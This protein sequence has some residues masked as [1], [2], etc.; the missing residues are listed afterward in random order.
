MNVPGAQCIRSLLSFQPGLCGD[1]LKGIVRLSSEDLEALSKDGL[2]SRCVWDG[3]LDNPVVQTDENFRSVTKKLAGKLQGRWVSIASDRIGQHVVRK[4]FASLTDVDVGKQ[5]VI[6]LSSGK[7]RLN[8]SAM[9]RSVMESCF[10]HEFIAK[11]EKEWT[12]LVRKMHQ[13]YTLAKEIFEEVDPVSA[14]RPDRKRRKKTDGEHQAKRKQ[15]LSTMSVDAIMRT[16]TIPS[17]K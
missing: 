3:I 2:G 14:E 4:L 16:L 13:K 10:V 5:L 7:A 12:T 8:G 9:G 1:T 11:G 17:S 15:K 6:E